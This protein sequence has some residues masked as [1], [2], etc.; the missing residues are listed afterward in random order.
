[1]LQGWMPSTN[2]HRF[3]CTP[4]RCTAELG[5]NKSSHR[6]KQ[7]SVIAELE[8]ARRTAWVNLR[9]HK[10]HGLEQLG[11]SVT[12]LP[13]LADPGPI[14]DEKPRTLAIGQEVGMPLGRVQN[15]S[16]V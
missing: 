3:S 14:A 11:G 6:L 12:D 16:D 5:W 4:V 13:T 15:L 8:T 1:M 2:H 7:L 9:K 10:G